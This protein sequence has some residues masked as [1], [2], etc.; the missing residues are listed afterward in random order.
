MLI[1]NET[2]FKISINII[3]FFVLTLRWEPLFKIPLILSIICLIYNK[4]P[5]PMGAIGDG[6][7]I[8]SLSLSLP[9]DP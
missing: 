6:L 5:S 1:N 3:F 9:Y 2:P 7:V 4:F 8:Y